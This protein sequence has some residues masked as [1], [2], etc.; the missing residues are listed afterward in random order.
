M[1]KNRLAIIVLNWNGADDTIKCIESLEAQTLRPT[2]VVVDNAS[3]DDSVTQISRYIKS[4]QSDIILIENSVNSGYTGG[5]NI[6]F[7]RALDD[8]YRYIGTLNPDA[9]ADKHWCE[10]L[11]KELD[12]HPDTGI[13]A[14]ILARSNHIHT[15]STG[16]FYT[17][18]GIPGPRGRDK[19]LTDAPKDA[20]YVFGVTGGGFI[21]RR[22]V[23]ER[24]GLLDERFFM[25]F[26]DVDLCFRTQLAG[27]KIRYQ[28]RAIAYH[29][30]SAST[31]KV[32]GLAIKQTFKNLPILFLKNVP[33]RL[34]PHILPRFWLS[35]TLIFWH[36]VFHGRGKFVFAGWFGSLALLPH[37]LR[38]RLRIQSSRNVSSDYID[39][40]ILHDIPPEQ[41]GLRKFRSFFTGKK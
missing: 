37:A 38:E 33:L 26:E 3:S 19:L 5:N 20:A 18:W 30:I 21:T 27:Y 11:V 23:F 16:D 31:N 25:Y 4:A 8:G 41:T 6:G 29:K 34:W 15:D 12:T 14:G 7:R 2:I 10:T 13:V 32:P 40:I 28:P 9:V 22:E 1:T 17:T 36:G 24:V 39:S 35:Y